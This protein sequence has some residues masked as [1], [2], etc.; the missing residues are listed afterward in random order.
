MQDNENDGGWTGYNTSKEDRPLGAYALLIGAFH[1]IFALFLLAVQ[2]SG[3]SLPERP[4]P[5]DILL[6]GIA[7]QKLSRL[8]AK[9]AVTSALRAPFTR[10]QGPA[11]EGE[12]ND[13]PRGRGLRHAVGELLTC[14]FCVSEWI[15]AFL[16]YGLVFAPRVTR[17]VAGLVATLTV[18]DFVQ[19]GYDMTKQQAERAERQQD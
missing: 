18:A 14:P 4:R 15:G 1:A 8:L 19:Y 7:T 13:A 12:V 17:F 2:R 6:L 10:Y 16:G 5:D 11:G 9:D 3:R